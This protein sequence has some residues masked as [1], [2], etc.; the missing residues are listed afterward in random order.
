MVTTKFTDAK[1]RALRPRGRQYETFEG[2]GFGV[3]VGAR[4]RLTW[5]ML[6]RCPRG[7]LRRLSFGTYPTMSLAVARRTFEDNLKL[8]AE[9]VDPADQ[10]ASERRRRREAP[11]VG[12]LWQM[13]DRD[14]VAPRLQPKTQRLYRD[15]WR[16]HIAPRLTD[17]KVGD[18]VKADVMSMHAEIGASG[19]RRTANVAREIVRCLWNFAFDLN[20]AAGANPAARI[21]PF[22]MTPRERFL[23]NTEIANLYRVLEEDALERR[24]WDTH[25]A[26]KLMLLTGARKSNVLGARWQDLDL[27]AARWVIPGSTTK[28]RRTY[29]VSL[30][31]GA[32][33]ILIRRRA[34]AAPT[35]VYV[36]P[37]RT[38]R[39]G[40][41]RGQV[42][43]LTDIKSS[44]SRITRRA[45]LVGFRLHD[46]RHVHAS[47]LVNSGASLQAVAHQLGHTRVA[48]AE[49][50]AVLQNTTVAGAVARAMDG[51]GDAEPLLSGDEKDPSNEGD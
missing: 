33:Q 26:V 9:G 41:A 19:R 50:Y 17:I 42:D 30:P 12:D 11:T 29:V 25:D 51:L 35:A 27:P 45:D 38:R 22:P 34:E 49:R 43:H 36:L 6:Y 48:M 39:V 4:G 16:L 44:W 10:F 1:L 14:H 24:D 47:L 7:K 46:L 31:P 13:F 23:T 2:R 28:T 21:K 8:L 15:V 3:R 37:G 32:V 20:L 40:E 18:L 5:I